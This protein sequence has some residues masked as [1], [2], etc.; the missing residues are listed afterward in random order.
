MLSILLAAAVAALSVLV[1]PNDRLGFPE[2][3]YLFISGGM[4]MLIVFAGVWRGM[5]DRR[6]SAAGAARIGRSIES[7]VFSMAI[8]FGA[9]VLLMIYAA[10]LYDN[11]FGGST[12]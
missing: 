9:S 11:L 3:P 12:P 7:V 5:R 10:L 2:E 1:A 8:A 6:E 4:M